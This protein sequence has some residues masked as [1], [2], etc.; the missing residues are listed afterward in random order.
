MSRR[1]GGAGG[2]KEGNWDMYIKGEKV[3][4]KNKLKNKGQETDIVT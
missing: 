2:E 4:L 3:G 1:W